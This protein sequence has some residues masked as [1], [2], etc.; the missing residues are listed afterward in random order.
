MPYISAMTALEAQDGE[1][2]DWVDLVDFCRLSGG[3]PT[4]LWRRAVF[5]AAVGNLDDHLR[6]HGFLRRNAA[7]VPSPAFDVNPEPLTQGD[8]HELMLFGVG[9]LTVDSF[10]SVDALDLFG[11]RPA[12]A[13][14][15][16][17]SLAEALTAAIRAAEI[18]GADGHSISVMR[19]R[20]DAAVT[21]LA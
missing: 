2:G 1:S 6:N 10:F 17:A 3:D 7:W 19:S 16:R 12:P 18:H 9:E 8:E 13:S 21:Q 11:V 4:E 20:V 5:G 14:D 15:F